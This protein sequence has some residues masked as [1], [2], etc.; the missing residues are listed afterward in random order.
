[1]NPKKYSTV[2]STN[3]WSF[4]QPSPPINGIIF[5][6]HIPLSKI[7]N[8]THHMSLLSNVIT[9]PYNTLTTI[10]PSDKDSPHIHPTNENDENQ[11]P[12]IHN[13]IFKHPKPRPWKVHSSTKPTHPS[14]YPYPRPPH[15]YPDS[16]QSSSRH[17]ATNYHFPNQPQ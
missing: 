7:K 8:L 14:S 2:S 17:V 3:Q 11:S 5:H 13:P 16:I 1:M 12:P 9:N 4:D 10:P 15:Y 6:I